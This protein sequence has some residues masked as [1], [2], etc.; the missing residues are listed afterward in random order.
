MEKII[1]KGEGMWADKLSPTRYKIHNIPFTILDIA[2][3]D[4][5][6]VDDPEPDR[7]KPVFRRVVRRSGNSTVGVIIEEDYRDKYKLQEL[8]DLGL[9]LEC[10]VRGFYS[11]N[12]PAGTDLDL[13]DRVL[14]ERAKEGILRYEWIFRFRNH[15]KK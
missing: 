4:I 15:K 1:V 6:L 2:L 10:A 13:I 8:K 12:V 14:K 11:A 7:L 5:V 3:H 9:S